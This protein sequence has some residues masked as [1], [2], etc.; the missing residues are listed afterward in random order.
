[1]NIINQHTIVSKEV[2]SWEDIA[3]D[4]ALMK[5]F[6]L[7]GK[8]RGKRPKAYALHHSQV[9]FQPYN[10][11]V[12][13]PNFI[14]GEAGIFDR[15]VYINPELIS[16]EDEQEMDEACMSFP[17]KKKFKKVKRFNEIIVDYFDEYGFCH[18]EHC[19]GIK[20]QIFQHEIDHGLGKT[21]YG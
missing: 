9:S 8:F 4:V 5:E 14:L 16:G 1:M 13:H 11:F 2:T 19:I 3:T 12:V 7:N 17:F 18:R 6:I 10:F 20:A 21:I 15:S